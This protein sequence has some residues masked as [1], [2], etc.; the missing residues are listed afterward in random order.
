MSHDLT[1]NPEFQRAFAAV[2]YFAGARG[3]AL[4]E[5]FA[6]PSAEL[7]AFCVALS[8]AEQSERARALSTELERLARRLDAR[9]LGP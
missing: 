6:A 4:L 3:A 8:A 7:E 9:R 5:P 2:A 1:Q